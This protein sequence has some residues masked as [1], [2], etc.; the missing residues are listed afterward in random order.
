MQDEYDIP[1]GNSTCSK[2]FTYLN[3]SDNLQSIQDIKHNVNYQL[4]NQTPCEYTQTQMINQ[5]E[6]Y[7]NYQN[8]YKYQ[9]KMPITH[10]KYMNTSYYPDNAGQN[11]VSTCSNDNIEKTSNYEINNNKSNEN[12][13]FANKNLLNQKNGIY[14]QQNLN[15]DLDKRL[16]KKSINISNPINFESIPSQ[17]LHANSDKGLLSQRLMIPRESVVFG[18]T[19]RNFNKIQSQ[20]GMQNN[21][22]TSVLLKNN[23]QSHMDEEYQ[24]YLENMHNDK[25]KSVLDPLKNHFL[26]ND[27]Y[28]IYGYNIKYKHI[29][30]VIA[31][32]IL[33]IIIYK[34]WKWIKKNDDK[35]NK[36]NRDENRDENKNEE[37]DK[38]KKK[39]DKKDKKSQDDSLYIPTY[40]NKN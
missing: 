14:H 2:I 17:N 12:C 13:S 26:N 19:N 3:N 15:M 22:N 7:D 32:I 30:Y 23:F 18:E 28:S 21:T 39:K 29:L 36:E 38:K 1:F 11:Y 9:H 16:N 40:N 20:N 6:L 8:E 5:P 27:I 10:N 31:T 25:I 34:I 33:L 37:E 4:D 35:R 24:K